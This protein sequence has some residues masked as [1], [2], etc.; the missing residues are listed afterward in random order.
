MA[1]GVSKIER[2]L[3]KN[4][5]EKLKK[6]FKKC[7]KNSQKARYDTAGVREVFVLPE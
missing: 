2:S 3:N 6:L 1:A 4:Y 7:K 5:V